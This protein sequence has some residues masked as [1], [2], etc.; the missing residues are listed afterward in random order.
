MTIAIKND[1]AQKIIDDLLEKVEDLVSRYVYEECGSL[2]DLADGEDDP[3]VWI[4]K[5]QAA[6]EET[7]EFL[8]RRLRS[9]LERVYKKVLQ[10]PAY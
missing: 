8:M 9:R 1:E 10:Q 5:H 3:D 7:F 6:M 4:D 2:S